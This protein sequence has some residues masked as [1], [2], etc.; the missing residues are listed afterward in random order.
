MDLS[1]LDQHSAD[2]P[3]LILSDI[4]GIP[5]ELIGPAASS[6]GRGAVK[7]WDMAMRVV[8]P[9]AL[10]R[11]SASDAAVVSFGLG[12]C[13]YA[14][15]GGV[16]LTNDSALAERVRSLRHA[17]SHDETLAAS[18]RH[19]LSLVART[20]A[21]TRA[22]YG[23]ARAAADWRSGRRA[24]ADGGATADPSGTAPGPPLS[25]EWTEPMTS[26]NRTLALHNLRNAARRADLRR[27][28]A[29]MYHRQLA[30][31]G[32]LYDLPSGT[33][34]QSHFPIRVP[35]HLRTGLRAEL[36]RRGVDTGTLFPFPSI[37]PRSQYPNAAQASDEVVLLPLG[38]R[39]RVDEIALVARRVADTVRLLQA[40]R[41][42]VG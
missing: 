25:R 18:M 26:I 14:G 19:T 23:M 42:T 16:L 33:L 17:W 32:V 27:R 10:A 39:I 30:P 7:I 13:L 34:P 6:T 41:V 22:L 1:K 5:C 38:E 37:L 2:A 35:A 9:E 40:D 21:H 12:K 4:Y 36:R 28:Q 31:V 29:E 20:A 24:A 3:T 11:M 8:T 15:W